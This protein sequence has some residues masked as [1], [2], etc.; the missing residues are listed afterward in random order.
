MFITHE[1]HVISST[2]RK[3]LTQRLQFRFFNMNHR[4]PALIQWRYLTIA[5]LDSF[6]FI[7]F[8]F[9]SFC[10]DYVSNEEFPT[11]FCSFWHL[12]S[13]FVTLACVEIACAFAWT[14]TRVWELTFYRQL[15]KNIG[16]YCSKKNEFIFL[17]VS[18]QNLDLK[19]VEIFSKC[20][21]NSFSKIFM[22][23]VELQFLII[24]RKN[25]DLFYCFS[26]SEFFFFLI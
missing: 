5:F 2:V 25:S 6:L 23:L 15:I 19:I 3:D 13:V 20:D 9:Y 16:N 17:E 21:A 24:S 8:F 14:L 1:H 7:Y 4:K 12:I 10:Y 18:E 26:I 11:R 22:A